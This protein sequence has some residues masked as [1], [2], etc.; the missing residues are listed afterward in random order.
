MKVKKVLS[1]AG[2]DPSGGAGIQADLKTF[3]ALGV[4]G[5]AVITCLTVQNTQSVMDSFPLPGHFVKNQI[6]AVLE[7]I[8]IGF[9]KTGMLGNAE[10]AEAV[11][12]SLSGHYVICDPVMISKSGF[13][14]MDEPALKAVE[15]F[16]VSE[17]TVLTPNYHELIRISGD[18]KQ[19]PVDSA[20]KIL[21]RFPKL[22]AVLVKGGHIDEEKRMIIDTLV[23][24][25]N[26]DFE[27]IDFKHPRFMTKNTHG[28]GCTLSSAVTAFLARGNSLTKAVRLAVRYVD[29]LIRLSVK[30]SIGKGNGPLPHHQGVKL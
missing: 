1:I 2:S 12:S 25:N 18:E 19:S 27:L 9:I 15:K 11:G 16:V 21:E 20:K 22:L 6:D 5:G 8:D 29:S 13:P 17:S 30:E 7:D 28:T 26:H 24:K 3:T 10:I 4:Y 14:L 23:M